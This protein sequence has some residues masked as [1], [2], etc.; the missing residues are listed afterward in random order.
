MIA[1]FSMEIALEAGMPTYS[2]GLGVLAGDTIRSAADMQLPM[3]CVTLLHRKGYFSQRLGDDGEQ[4]EEPVT[5]AV[6]NYLEEMEERTSVTIAGRTVG[7]RAWK[8]EVTGCANYKIP[9]LLLDT[10]L[11]E[12]AAWDRKLT[13][14]L[15]GGDSKYRLCQEVV[16][17]IGGVR[18]LRILGYDKIARYHMNEG[19]ASLLT[20]ELLNDRLTDSGKQSVTV[21]DCNYVRELCIFTTHTPVPAGHDHFPMELVEEILGGHRDFFDR[22]DIF[23]IDLVNRILESESGQSFYPERNILAPGV[24]LNMTYLGLNLS[25]YI[26][27]VAKKHG[28][29]ARHMFGGYSIDSITNGIHIATWASQHFQE[30]F[31][32][33]IPGWKED[34]FSLRYAISIPEDQIW[35]TH[36]I[37]KKELISRVSQQ[38]LIDLDPEILTIGFA[39]RATA[40]KRADLLFDDIPRLKMIVSD[41]GKLQIIYA[42]KAHP[43]DSVGKGL[44]RRLF[45]LKKLFK[46]HIEI[47]YLEGYDMALG[48]LMTSGVDIWLN[49]PEPPLEASG[50]SGMKAAVNGVPSLS[51]LDGWWCEGCIEGITGW[52]IGDPTQGRENT[53]AR[54]EDAVSLYDK[55]E[56]H[57]IPMYYDNRSAFID[58]M[59]HAIAL[60]GSFFNTQR[61]L[62]QYV[63]KAYFL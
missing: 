60:N 38:T 5:W 8:Y 35:D 49:T 2:G 16:L 17:G 51:I 23:C 59:R 14:Y 22:T 39:R 44:I 61:M 4:L 32:Y 6:E 20:L 24:A 1:Y 18:M 52:S 58:V 43:R 62:Q 19:H 12:N 40:Y 36:M 10:D 47:V 33:Y 13:H 50:T 41:V 34:N 3:V 45:E 57:V 42:G 29:V 53:I 26:N 11:E 9:V 25:H 31:D 28:E 30:L 15:Y 46:S 48:K 21:D 54:S 63:Q 37:A 55:L 7:V 27:G 56:N